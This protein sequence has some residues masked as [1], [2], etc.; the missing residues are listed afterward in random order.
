MAEGI[1]LAL[2]AA[3]RRRPATEQHARFD[4]RPGRLITLNDPLALQY[5]IIHTT[6]FERAMFKTLCSIFLTLLFATIDCAQ[7]ESVTLNFNTNWAYR[8]GNVSD[9]ERVGLDDADWVA[10]TIPHTLAMEK[11]HL[12]SRNYKGIGWYRRYF[13]L[14]PKFKGREINIDFAGVMIDCDVFLN[15]DKIATHHGGYIGFSVDITDKVRFGQNNLLAVR[16]SNLD[17]ADTPPGKPET[18]LDFHYFGGIYGDVALRIQDRL[19]ITD[20][21][22]ADEVAGG[23]VFV[24][25]PMVSSERALVHVKTEI[26]NDR[27]T[28]AMFTLKTTLLDT[29]G[30]SVAETATPAALPSGN[31]LNLE[32]DLTL[33]HPKLWHPDQP[34]LYTL[35]SE[36]LESGT[37]VDSLTTPIGVR[38][39]AF[40][41]DG[42]YINGEKLYIRGA[43]RHQQFQNVGDAASDSMQRRDAIALKEGGFNAVRGH[44][45]NAKAFLD[46]CDELGILV[47]ESQPGWQWWSADKLFWDNTI[48]DARQMIRRDRNRPS[49][50]LWETTL[51]ETPVP[52]TWRKAVTDAAHQEYPGDQLFVSCDGVSPY[53]NVGYKVIYRKQEWLDHDPKKPFV[54]R[55]WGDWE[56]GSRCLRSDGETAMIRQ[57]VYRQ[58]Y[59]NG[60]GYDDWGGLDSCDRIAGYFLWSWMDYTRGS[61]DTTLGSGAVDINRYPKFC[62]Y[63]L[64]SMTDARNSAYGPMVFIA[65]YNQDR[66]SFKTTVFSS[67]YQSR[68][69]GWSVPWSSSDIMVFSNCDSVRL[70][71]NG[72]LIGEMART[73]NSATAPYIAQRGGS[74]Y[75]VFNRSKF[76]PGTLL[77]QGI[78]D[79][80]VV[81]THEVRTPET[82]ARVEIVPS[83][84]GMPFVADGSDLLPVYFKIVDSNGTLVPD[85]TNAIKITV[86][87]EGQLVGKGIPRLNVEDQSVDAGLG[88]AFIRSSMTAGK[89]TIKA[90]SKGLASGHWELVSVP[91]T[92]QF[93]ADGK[94]SSWTHDE[95]IFEPI[96]VAN[97]AA[98]K[99]TVATRVQIPEDQIAS[100]TASCPSV[101]GRGTDRLIDGQT[102]FGTGWLADSQ[103]LPQSV[104]FHFKEPQNI[105]AAQIFWEKDST[106][107]GY[108]LETSSDGVT[109]NK[110]ISSKTATGHDSA[111]ALFKQVQKNVR[112]ARIII[113]DVKTGTG[114]VV[115]GIA[116]A[117]FFR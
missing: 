90:E 97:E 26:A 65:S 61:R 62:S 10:V 72:S 113:K 117:R 96:I 66:E 42:F 38:R 103:S 55:E 74:P 2:L 47:I 115:I 116:E 98:A 112:F 99:E 85:A 87:G 57:V 88:F 101:S 86:E 14:E 23:G 11:K 6:V 114:L 34:N 39:I 22:Q 32:Q 8:L 92:C 53:Y 81:A 70:Y 17:D 30:R 25:Y 1:P 45:P 36:I 15:G 49:V 60:D 46:A 109:W 37:T 102:D 24:T 79:G 40:K 110:V 93:V 107:Y 48:R 51:N 12:G 82:A 84:M 58:V 83:K 33:T 105:T 35:I 76:E 108:D 28:R 5:G 104:T 16:V 50:V 63:W 95:R 77:A 64:R 4:T 13:I 54:T 106:W 78:L 59:L 44:Y 67:A 43:N 21:I 56:G 41:P 18:Q 69:G 27:L 31:K 100:I 3:L 71:Q 73:N 91:A 94:H 80:K 19:R 7:G 20:A 68:K 111:L 9:G 52:D 75:F 29:A 89:I